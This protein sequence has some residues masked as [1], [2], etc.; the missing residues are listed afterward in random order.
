MR[1]FKLALSDTAYQLCCIL[2][3]FWAAAC[4]Y[5]L[6]TLPHRGMI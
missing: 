6:A 1:A 4:L 3:I 5:A 2:P